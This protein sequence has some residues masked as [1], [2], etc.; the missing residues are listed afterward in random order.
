MA[1]H[2]DE[3]MAKN[4]PCYLTEISHAPIAYGPLMGPGTIDLSV[5]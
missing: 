4:L 3:T 5:I 1:I 2:N